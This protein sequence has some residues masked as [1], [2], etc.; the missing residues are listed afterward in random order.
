MLAQDQ[1]VREILSRSEAEV[2]LNNVDF[3]T[4]GSGPDATVK[5]THSDAAKGNTFK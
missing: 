3:S 5:E 2:N 4:I 1:A